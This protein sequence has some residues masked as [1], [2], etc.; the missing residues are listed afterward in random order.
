MST[1]GGLFLGVQSGILDPV[2]LFGWFGHAD[3]GETKNT[4]QLVVDF[5]NDHTLTQPYAELVERNPAMANLAVRTN[6]Q[7]D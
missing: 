4:V 5:M 6:F 7:K 3:A 1:L 2:V